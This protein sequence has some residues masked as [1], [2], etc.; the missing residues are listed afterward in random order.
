M[1]PQFCDAERQVQY[2]PDGRPQ[3]KSGLGE[4]GAILRTGVAR[5]VRPHPSIRR[6]EGLSLRRMKLS[7][8]VSDTVFTGDNKLQSLRLRSSLNRTTRRSS[9]SPK[10]FP[11]ENRGTSRLPSG[12]T[13]VSDLVRITGLSASRL[14]HLFKA[15]TGTSISAFTK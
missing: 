11:F 9:P 1:P 8:Q 2:S 12:R 3:S 15:Q 10:L 7:L 13:R 6:T 14:Q 4:Q 5:R